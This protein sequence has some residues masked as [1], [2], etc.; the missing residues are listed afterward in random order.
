V[1]ALAQER[2][3]EQRRTLEALA[4][5][6]GEAHAL[7]QACAPDDQMWRSRMQR[8]LEVEAPDAAF[9]AALAARFNGGF[10]LRRREF[11]KCDPRASRVEAEVAARGRTLA[12]ALAR[13]P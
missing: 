13:E 12:D 10:D 5:V 1:P 6:L 11:A 4:G 2:T 8:L 3:P 9:A 7:R